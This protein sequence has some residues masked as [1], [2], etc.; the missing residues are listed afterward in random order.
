MEQNH[1]STRS[2]TSITAAT[3]ELFVA[4]GLFGATLAFLLA[5]SYPVVTALL[6]T[7]ALSVLVLEAV[8]SRLSPSGSVCVPGTGVCIRPAP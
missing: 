3:S 6:L 2:G 1:H 8:A 5:A 4:V 7:G